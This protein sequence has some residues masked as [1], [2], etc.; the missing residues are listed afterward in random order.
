MNDQTGPTAIANTTITSSG[1]H[2]IASPS[3]AGAARPI[4]DDATPTRSLAPP[5]DTPTIASSSAWRVFVISEDDYND[6]SSGQ[7]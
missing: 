1:H 6:R 4:T 5:P 3:A 7:C 2:F